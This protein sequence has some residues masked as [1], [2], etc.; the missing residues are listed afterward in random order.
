MQV[1]MTETQQ[2]IFSAYVLTDSDLAARWGKTINAVRSMRFRKKSP[3]YIKIQGSVRYRLE[4]IVE[5]G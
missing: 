4:D 2:A 3:P 1:I 5:H